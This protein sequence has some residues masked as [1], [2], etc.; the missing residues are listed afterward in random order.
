M[1]WWDEI[2]RSTLTL[3]CSENL[4]RR[5]SHVDTQIGL[6]LV[7]SPRRSLLTFRKVVGSIVDR[8]GQVER[9]SNVLLTYTLKVNID[10]IFSENLS[11]RWSHVDPRIGLDLVTSSRRSLLTFRK[12]VGS[13]VD[14]IGQVERASNVLLTYTLKVNI[15][16]IFFRKPK[17]QMKSCRPTDWSRPNDFT[18]KV[19]INL[20]KGRGKYCGSD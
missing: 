12:V 14:K 16:T 19:I 11:R 7:T 13:I 3:F 4:S 10:T 17:L 18:Q 15:D 8:I 20:Q 5:W 2:A 6:D 9:A 1:S